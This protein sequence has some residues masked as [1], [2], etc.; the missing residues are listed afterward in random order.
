[1]VD[2]VQLLIVRLVY[3]ME[4]LRNSHIIVES[5]IILGFEVDRT[6]DRIRVLKEYVCCTYIKVIYCLHKSYQ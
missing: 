1:M 4:A 2:V 3:Q 6:L 5:V